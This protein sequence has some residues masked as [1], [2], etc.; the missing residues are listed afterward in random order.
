MTTTNGRAVLDH[1][2]AEFLEHGIACSRPAPNILRLEEMGCIVEMKASETSVDILIDT[3]S[4]NF[5]VFIREEVIEH[6]E[7]IAPDAIDTLRWTGSIKAG[8]MPSNFRVLRAS[9]RMRVHPGLIRVTLEGVDVEALTKDGIHMRLM[10]PAQR[11]RKPVWPVINENGATV[12]PQGDDKLHSRY[13]TIRAIRPDA[14]EV[15]IDI[16]HHVGGLISDWAALEDD[17]QEVGVMGPA[18]DPHLMHTDNVVLAADVT[19]LPAIAR[20][21]ASVQGQVTGHVFVAAPSQQALDDYLPASSLR[22]TAVEPTRFADDVADY[23]RNC[24]KEPVSYGWFAGEFK[25]AQA[26]RKV[27]KDGFGL[28]KKSQLSVAYWKENAPGHQSRAR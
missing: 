1:C 12:W 27:F 13:V 10:M 23:I 18:G 21:I 17:D 20:L 8:E 7:E 19:G 9:R 2:G 24:T 6:L 5:L 14:R 3:P 15:D 4:E 16:A 25:A 22:L 28:D 26:V 11:G